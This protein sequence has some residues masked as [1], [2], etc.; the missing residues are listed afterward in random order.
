MEVC[1]PLFDQVEVI[2]Y[3]IWVGVDDHTP[4]FHYS[5]L[6]SLLVRVCLMRR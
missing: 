3:Y 1:C 6:Q 2:V 4:P 5:S